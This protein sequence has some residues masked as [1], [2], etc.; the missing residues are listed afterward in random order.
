MSPGFNICGSSLLFQQLVSV[1]LR[2]KEKH[3]GSK[4]SAKPLDLGILKFTSFDGKALKREPKGQ[5]FRSGRLATVLA[6]RTWVD[7]KADV[8]KNE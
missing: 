4:V 2:I 3:Q 1:S 7:S 8:E 6:K 5:W